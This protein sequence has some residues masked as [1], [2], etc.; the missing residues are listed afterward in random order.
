MKNEIIDSFL[1]KYNLW[2]S[3][4]KKELLEKEKKNE[5]LLQHFLDRFTSSY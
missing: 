3:V 2:F 4:H 1:E 5:A